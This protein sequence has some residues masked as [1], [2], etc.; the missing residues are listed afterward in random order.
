MLA[1]E[2]G[3]KIGLEVKDDV[4]LELNDGKQILLQLKHSIQNN[5]AGEIINLTERDTDL[6]KTIYNWINIINDVADG[7]S[8]RED[9]L[10][11]IDNTNFILVSNKSSNLNNTFLIN[12]ENFKKAL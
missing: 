9:Q 7:R 1:L 2:E 5:S 3:E 6:W 12:V 10:R 11:F 8:K 4:H